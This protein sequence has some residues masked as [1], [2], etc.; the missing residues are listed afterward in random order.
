L[1]ED[2]PLSEREKILAYKTEYVLYEAWL[3]RQAHLPVI[4]I[5]YNDLLTDPAVPVSYLCTFL[6]G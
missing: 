5:N 2:S 3:M 4:F 6:D 1:R